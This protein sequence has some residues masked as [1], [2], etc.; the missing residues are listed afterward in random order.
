MDY[1]QRNKK[2]T[3]I[4]FARHGRTRGVTQ[5]EK[6]AVQINVY[7]ENDF[8]KPIMK[9]LLTGYDNTISKRIS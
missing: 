1:H 6:I 5:I 7:A 2:S 8:F 3:I 4:P 9:S